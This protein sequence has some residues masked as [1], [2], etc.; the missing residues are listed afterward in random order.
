MSIKCIFGIHSWDGCICTDCK[1]SRD[2]KHNWTEDCE[3]CSKCGKTMSNKHSWVGCTCEKCVAT[4]HEWN[5]CTC[6]QCSQTRDFDHVWNNSDT[7]T[8]CG[9][10]NPEKFRKVQFKIYPRNPVSVWDLGKWQGRPIKY[11]GENVGKAL[12]VDLKRDGSMFITTELHI[13]FAYKTL[14]PDLMLYD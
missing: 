13:D 11:N 9:K 2:E 3:R 6:T 1:K 14:G 5:G 4:R 7:C 8:R 12:I 10:L